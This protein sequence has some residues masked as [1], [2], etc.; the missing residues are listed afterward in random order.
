MNQPAIATAPET[1]AAKIWCVYQVTEYEWWIGQSIDDVVRSYCEVMTC[2]EADCEKYGLLDRNKVR[3]LTDDE[4][5]RKVF[6]DDIE[7]APRDPTSR[8]SFRAELE[9]VLRV[10][11]PEFPQ[12]F[13]TTE[14]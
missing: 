1:P 6:V 12:F 5:D 14:I 2:S 13:A 4:L 10:E 7:C 9:R 3:A 11:K 8:R